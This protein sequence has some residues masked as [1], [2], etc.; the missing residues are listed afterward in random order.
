MS[1]ALFPVWAYTDAD[2]P[3]MLAT[4]AALEQN[5]SRKGLLYWRRLECS[6][7]RREGAFLAGTFWVAQYWIMRGELV[8]ARRSGR[9]LGNM[10][11]AF[12]HAAF[13]GAV[14]DLKAA[15]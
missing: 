3:E 1:A 13:I 14:V 15:G 5:W 11:Q 6:D 2:T 8:R 7:S 12:V 4:I 9:M 10:P